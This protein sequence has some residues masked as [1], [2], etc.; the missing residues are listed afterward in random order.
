ML[1][2]ALAERAT[3]FADAGAKAHSGVLE[4]GNGAKQDA[5][6]EGNEKREK[7]DWRINA[8]FTDA[9]KPRGSHSRK[10]AQRAISEAHTDGAAEQAENDAFEQ[11]IRSDASA[12]GAQGGADGE[13]LTAAFDADEQQIGDIGAGDQEDH[14]DRA[15]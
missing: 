6:E 14:A 2:L 10:N 5:G 15:H 9:R 3:A 13:L 12:A 4:D 7:Q 1:L 11:K 8:D